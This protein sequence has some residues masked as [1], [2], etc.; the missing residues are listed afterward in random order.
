MKRRT[1]SSFVLFDVT[2]ADGSLTSR[3]KVPTTV[4]ESLDGEDAAKATIEAQ[5]RE[6]ALASGKDRGA[7]KTMVRSRA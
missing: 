6:I 7:I 5:D 1:L 4:V 2:Y 3:R